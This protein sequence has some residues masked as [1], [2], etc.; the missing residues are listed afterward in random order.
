M[1]FNIFCTLIGYSYFPW[2][3]IGCE[4]TCNWKRKN[5]LVEFFWVGWEC[6]FVPFLTTTLSSS[7][8]YVN[9]WWLLETLLGGPMWIQWAITTILN[10]WCSFNGLL[11]WNIWMLEKLCKETHI[12]IELQHPT[13]IF[14]GPMLLSN[15]M[16]KTNTTC[17]SHVQCFQQLSYITWWK[18]LHKNYFATTPSIMCRNAQMPK[19]GNVWNPIMHPIWATYKN[20]H[21]SDET[22]TTHNMIP[23]PNRHM[24]PLT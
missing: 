4:S 16:A 15:V 8:E 1:A 9:L 23:M 2:G 5:V 13:S 3:V 19:L 14:H 12:V 7:R 17:S 6:G 18:S 20:K 22:N 24:N 21:F 10:T 11:E